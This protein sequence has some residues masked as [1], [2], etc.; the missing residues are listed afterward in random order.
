MRRKQNYLQADIK[1]AS[2]KHYN[3]KQTTLKLW[4]GAQGKHKFAGNQVHLDACLLFLNPFS[5]SCLYLP[6]NVSNVA[7]LCS[8]IHKCF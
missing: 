4:Q 7:Q 3:P 2:L 6:I 8:C 5:F 1:G